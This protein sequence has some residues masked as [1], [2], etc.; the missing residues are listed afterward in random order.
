LSR[1]AAVLTLFLIFTTDTALAGTRYPRVARDA[2]G[3]WICTDE[4]LIQVV[5]DLWI[6]YTSADGLPSDRVRM[7]A[8]D[9]REVW[10][11]TPRGLGRMDRSSRRWMAHTAPD[12]LPSDNVFSVAVDDRYVWVGTAKGAVRYDKQTRDWARLTEPQ[13]PQD[14]PVFDI[15]S[16]GK[17]V[18]FATAR[19]VYLFDRQT[20]QWRHFGEQEGFNLGEVYE[21]AQMGESL[22]FFCQRGLVRFDLRSRAVSTFSQKEGLPS[23]VVTAFGAVQGDIW[24]GTDQGLVVYS[25]G[26]DAIS[27]F[28]YEKGM[29]QGAVRGIEVSLPW[30]FVGTDSGLGMF[31]TLQK[32]W[33]EKREA[34]GLR[35]PDTAGLALAGT[36]LILLQPGTYQGYMI[37]RDE[38]LTYSVDDVWSGKTGGKKEASA[39]RLNLELTVSGEGSYSLSQG[40]SDWE[41]SAQFIPELRLGMGASLEGGRSLDA[42]VRMDMGDVMPDIERGF[43]DSLDRPGG[44]F[45]ERSAKVEGGLR[46]YDLEVRFRGNEDDTIKEL[47]L[48]DEVPLLGEENRHDLLDH[49][50]LEG[51]GVYQRLGE[52]GERE[53][54]P[55]E[56]EAE[57]GLRRGVRM[58]EFFRGS[59]DLTCQLQKQYITPESYVVKVDGMILERGVDYI[60][61]HTTGQLTF[62]NPDRVNALSLVEITY[63]YEQI[64]R[65]GT[66]ARSILEMLPWDNELGNFTRDGQPAYVTDES[67]LYYQIDGAAP[68][69]IDRGWVESVF[70]KYIQSSTGVEVNIHDMGT[71][72]NA[73]DM[74]DYD[75]PVSYVV[76]WEE[77]D[78]VALLDQSL[79]SGYAVKMLMDRYYVELSIDEKS[80]SSEILIELFAK[81]IKT[82]GSLEGTNIDS[83]RPLVGRLHVGVNPSD[84]F[85]FGGGYLGSQDVSDREVTDRFGVYPARYEMAMADLWTNHAIGGGPY[86]GK[87]SSFFQLGGSRAEAS[88]GRAASGNLIYNSQNLNVRLDG[89]IHSRDFETLGSRQTPLGTFAGD[90]RADTTLMP[91]RWLTIR[92]LY[93]HERSYLAPD[94]SPTGAA[95]G[96]NENLMG[97]LAFMKARWPTVWLLFGRSVL[98]GGGHEDEKLRLAGSLEYDLAKGILDGLGFRKLAVKAYFDHSQ[99]EVSGFETTPESR[100]GNLGSY[101]GA[102]QNMRLELKAAPTKTEDGYMRF[103]RKTFEPDEISASAGQQSM[104]AWELVMGAASRYLEGLVP[105][106]NGKMSYFNGRT[107]AG[108]DLET[109]AALLSGQLELFPGRW[110]DALGS[111]MLAVGYGYTNAEE[112]ENN[113]MKIHLQK[114]Q[115]EGRGA[116]GK[117]D[118][119]FRL[120]SRGKWW[121]VTQDE[122]QEDTERYVEVLNRLTY[123]PIYTSPITLRFDFSQMEQLVERQW[124]TTHSFLPSV[125]WERRWSHDLIT[126]IRMEY[127]LR[128]RDNVMDEFLGVPVSYKEWSLKPWAEIR[129]RLQDFWKGSL[130]RLTV[131]GYFQW[132]D[133]FE[134]GTGAERAWEA[135][136]SVYVDWEKAGSFIVR[137][138]II[139]TRHQCDTRV[140]VECASFHA[141]KPSIKAIARF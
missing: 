105:T 7:V 54:D 1:R 104:E 24:I 41:K 60:V 81:A 58:R 28:I 107:D 53:K 46:D 64:P 120:E 112:S 133:W 82:K 103:E 89:E 18:W 94:L 132:I 17:S 30:V 91:V 80:R 102:A 118:D 48:S 140:G 115:V 32:V 86:G 127:P 39:I 131:R 135:S 128:L 123:R 113:M 92:M 73:R 2:Q 134:Q 56:V 116:F 76:L 121:K 66:D 111:T 62:L 114:H 119:P 67:G 49:A 97:K 14:Q 106:F 43:I 38:W 130:L 90:V 75:R 139:Y 36:T 57:A 11:A 100:W 137:I 29:P 33:E 26:A 13:G 138:G 31:N 110:I 40:S 68:K 79:P 74:F 136:S 5:G 52:R 20:R 101:A 44:I 124:G 85:G 4:A 70:V 15:L 109:A 83:L 47:L 141:L 71:P 84:R 37:S 9:T 69:Y 117:Y 65:K 8:S 16:A 126:K 6:F 25:P 95:D 72:E 93:D 22:W 12:P 42:S 35:S 99:N 61:T 77:P 96:I 98:S 23:P 122:T 108:D 27:P 21:I 45:L 10:A 59:I 51:L 78:S 129:V 50:W 88:S 55:V 125:E 34:D 19:G 63:T 3:T 87:L